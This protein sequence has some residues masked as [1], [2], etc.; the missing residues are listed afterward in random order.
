MHATSSQN[1]DL[2]VH[3][4][5]SNLPQHADWI[6]AHVASNHWQ[7]VYVIEERVNYLQNVNLVSA[8]NL[9]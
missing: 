3:H 2:T 4:A 8:Q 5:T 1:P 7:Y 9:I 6:A